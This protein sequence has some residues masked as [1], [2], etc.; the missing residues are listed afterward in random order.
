MFYVRLIGRT[1]D[2][3]NMSEDGW[4]SG[5]EWKV[6][7]FGQ[8]AQRRAPFVMWLWLSS[9]SPLAP[10]DQLQPIKLQQQNA[11]FLPQNK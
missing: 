9:S 5:R 11:R 8:K 3:G 6:A 2:M 4:A 7:R 1:A 10:L